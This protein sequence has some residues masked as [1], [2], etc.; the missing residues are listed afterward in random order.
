MSNQNSYRDLNDELE[1]IISKL[2]SSDLDV[3]QVVKEYER[4]KIL[5]K[6]LEDY[7]KSASNKITKITTINSQT[8]K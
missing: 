3:D 2:Q 6:Q 1:L 7:L 5:I 4:A 8:K